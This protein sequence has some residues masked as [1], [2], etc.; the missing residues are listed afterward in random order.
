MLDILG[1]PFLTCDGLSRR[2]VLRVGVLGMAGLTLSD[3]LR[4]RARAA[5]QGRRV[6][7]TAVIQVFLEG[8]PSHIDTFDPKP[9]APAEFRGEFRAIAGN[10][11]GMEVCELLP[12]MARVMDKVALLRSV[13]H[14]SA[15]HGVGTH[16][17]MTGFPGELSHRDNVRP[18]VGAIVSRLKGANAPGVPPYVA[19]PAAPAFGLGAYLGPGGNPFSPDAG[20]EGGVRVRSLEP[21]PSLTLDRLDD[22]RDLLARLDRIERSRDAS[23]MM[24]GMDRFTAEAYAMVTGPRARA[25]FDLSREEPRLRDRYGRTRVGQACLLARRLVEAGVTFVT[26]VEGGWDHHGQLF[27]GCRR[28]LPPLDAALASLVEDLHERGL[29]ERVLVVVWGEFG[30]TPRLNGQG[31]RDHWPGC[32][33]VLLTGGSLRMGQLIGT[34]GRRGEAPVD[35]ALRP[36][37]VLRTV[38]QVLAI[39]PH[40]EFRNDAGRP[41]AVLNQGQPITELLASGA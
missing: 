41:L 24:A 32:M 16:W 27:A 39:D 17:I 19:L 33:S 13:H 23:G 36:E 5:E 4:L 1:A 9:D 25:A 38:Y 3:L 28:Q 37:D 2:S 22:R 8:G 21:P 29:H 6:Q 34:T 18:S 31:G 10:V 40:H 12:R 14:T 26:V 7:P 30:R 11:P 20:I 35:R 15:D